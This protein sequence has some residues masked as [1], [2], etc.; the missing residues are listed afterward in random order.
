MDMRHLEETTVKTKPE[1][2]KKTESNVAETVRLAIVKA[3]DKGEELSQAV[4]EIT[5]KTVKEALSKQKPSVKKVEEVAADAAKGF[6][7]A[8]SDTK[9]KIAD[10]Y[11]RALDGISTGAE[12]FGDKAVEAAKN[13]AEK[14]INLMRDAGE[15]ASQMIKE[16]V[17][18]VKEGF[19]DHGNA[20]KKLIQTRFSLKAESGKEVFLAGSFNEWNPKK[21]R[22]KFQNGL[23]NLNLELPAGRHEYKF[24]VDGVWTND[25]ECHEWSPNEFG[26][27]NNV[28]NVE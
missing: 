5:Q 11:H 26:V 9:L 15:K 13:A 22:I 25:P 3:A 17:E 7:Q 4:W 14:T 2:G 12:S 8:A 23:Y 6:N 24:V 27:A 21:N 20:S 1:A 18:D 19:K 16:A 10:L 28:I